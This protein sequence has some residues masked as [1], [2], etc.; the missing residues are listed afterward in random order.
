MD[1]AREEIINSYFELRKLLGISNQQK[2]ML[3]SIGFEE[4]ATHFFA[5]NSYSGQ[6]ILLLGRGTDWS[7]WSLKTTYVELESFAKFIL[8]VVNSAT[9][10]K[11]EAVFQAL[12]DL[13]GY[14]L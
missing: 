11:T 3:F 6:R 13:L 9:G 14:H 10:F 2:N 1:I 7:W 12:E 5:T 8:P 4:T